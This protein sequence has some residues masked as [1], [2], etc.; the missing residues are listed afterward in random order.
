MEQERHCLRHADVGV[1][2]LTPIV[3]PQVTRV[4]MMTMA[5]AAMT[6]TMLAAQAPIL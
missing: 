5:V 4:M 1:I 3:V 2:A 6:T